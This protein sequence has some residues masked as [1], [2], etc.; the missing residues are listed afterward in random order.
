ML[1]SHKVVPQTLVEAADISSKGAKVLLSRRHD[2]RLIPFNPLSP[3]LHLLQ[4]VIS[5]DHSPYS[6]DIKHIDVLL[7]L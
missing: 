3:D 2:D 1:E 5:V 6:I 4:F 7:L